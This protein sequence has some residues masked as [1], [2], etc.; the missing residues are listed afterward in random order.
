[1]IE[2]VFSDSAC[3]SLKMAQHYGE[4]PFR[5]GCVGVYVIHEDGSPATEDE[6]QAARREAEAQ[7]RQEWERGAPMGG[8]PADVYGFH[9]ALS[10]GDIS[11][12][13]PGPL[14]QQA[15]E[16][17]YGRVYPQENMAQ[18]LLEGL[19][20]TLA[21][22]QSRIEGG[23]AVRIWYSGQ[24]DELCGLYWFMTQLPLQAGEVYLVKLPEWELREDGTVLEPSSWGE[25]SPGQ[26]RSYVSLQQPAPPSFRRRCRDLWRG[27]QRE[28]APLRA[29]INGRLVSVPE[30]LYDGFIRR[31][32]AAEPD[33]FP[34]ARVVGSVLGKYQLGIGDLWVALRIEEMCRSGELEPVTE[35]PPDMPIYHRR[36]RKAAAPRP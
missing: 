16:K 27:L 1:M 24:P 2:I 15:L 22:V 36:L 35:T 9:L 12:D 32:I 34:E 31:E 13:C 6:I 25:I 10:M 8:S 28:N 7:A 17:L 4:G 19:E 30:T 33:T 20:A 18:A 29:V 26:W 5:S 21:A 11:E 23:E 3:G 14:R